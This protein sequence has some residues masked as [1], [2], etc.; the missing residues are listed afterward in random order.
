[1]PQVLDMMRA[2]HPI[3]QGRSRTVSYRNGSMR[4]LQT[5]CS[6]VTCAV[7]EISMSDAILLTLQLSESIHSIKKI[8][9][10]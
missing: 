4:L 2:A 9:T 3:A 10:R 8:R 1:M 7:K 6:P 5:E